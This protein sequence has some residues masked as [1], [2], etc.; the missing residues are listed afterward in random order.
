MA[1][2][3][4]TSVVAIK[5]RKWTTSVEAPVS[6]ETCCVL[7]CFLHHDHSVPEDGQ[8]RLLFKGCWKV[9]LSSTYVPAVRSEF[10]RWL[11]ALLAEGFAFTVYCSYVSIYASV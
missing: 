8:E 7:W 9:G 5:R 6:K 4:F 11:R 3:C 1:W 10:Q 2:S